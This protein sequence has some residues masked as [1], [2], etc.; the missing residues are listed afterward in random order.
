MK[1]F[2]VSM[3]MGY[4]AV[5]ICWYLFMGPPPDLHT[6]AGGVYLFVATILGG[7]I[8]LDMVIFAEPK[9][10]QRTES[11]RQPTDNDM[12][13]SRANAVAAILKEVDMEVDVTSLDD[14]VGAV[15]KIIASLSAV[16]E[17]ETRKWLAEVMAALKRIDEKLDELE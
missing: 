4:G 9:K 1:K 8:L 10:P 6:E 17:V 2:I 14:R 3:M 15:T 5:T 13:E 7:M 11:V 12:F 16:D